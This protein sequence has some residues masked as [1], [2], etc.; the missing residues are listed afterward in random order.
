MYSIITPVFNREDCISRC[1]E[2]V[3]E[4]LKWNIPLEHIIID[5]GSKDRTPSIINN[6]AKKYNHIKC[7]LLPTNKGT[8]AARNAGIRAAAGDFCTFLDSD[9][10]FVPD[11]ISFIHQTI[12]DKPNFIH[13]IFTPSH[14]VEKIKQ[15]VHNE[16]SNQCILTYSDFLS[17]KVYG[18]FLHVIKT[19]TLR[20]YPF[21]ESVRIHEYLTYLKLYKEANYILLTNKTI[22]IIE[23]QRADSV[24]KETIRT[25]KKIINKD[26][27]AVEYYLLNYKNELI[28][29]KL[30]NILTKRYIRYIE[31]TL[32][33]S[34]YNKTKKAL[35][36]MKA[37]SLSIPSY[38]KIFYY[39]RTG[40]LFR[41]LLKY[42]L[43]WKYR[44]W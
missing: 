11:A 2:S 6:Y 19:N 34:Q 42:Y 27:E 7:I 28:D 20:K 44:N 36:E 4:Q 37:L 1:I 9:D 3:I 5:D 17:G 33:L 24:T 12:N 30:D 8:N 40:W 25:S 10:Y 15:Y 14:Q 31:N 13:Y 16:S 38:L 43:E 29:Y 21:L 39:T 18:D 26:L 35:N 23:R 22:T 41:L 32:M